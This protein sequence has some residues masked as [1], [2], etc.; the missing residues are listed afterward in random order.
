MREVQANVAGE[1][2]NAALIVTIDT[3]EWNDIHPLDKKTIADRL[4]LAARKL[5]YGERITAGGPEYKSFETDG[6]RIIIHFEKEGGKL[7]Q[8]KKLEGFAIAGSDK[9]FVWAEAWTEGNTVAVKS[10][11]VANPKYVRYA[12]ADNPGEVNLFNVEGFPAGPFRTDK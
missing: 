5:A 4:A 7:A 10:K 9:K 12:W 11:Q 2:G 8:N 3:G 6:D 1:D